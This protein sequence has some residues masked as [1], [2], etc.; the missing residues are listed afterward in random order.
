LSDKVIVKNELER[1]RRDMV[2]AKIE[3]LSSHLPA[4]TK[5]YHKE[6]QSKL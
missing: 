6:T 4:E 1:M 3:A 2:M 5:K